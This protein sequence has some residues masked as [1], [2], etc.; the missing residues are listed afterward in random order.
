[1]T[2][3]AIDPT[4]RFSTR[5]EFYARARPRYPQA[6]LK[7][8][9]NTLGLKPVH[10]VADVGSGTGFLSELFLQNGNRVFAIEPNE[11]M[12]RKAEAALGS[13]PSFVSIDATAESTGL[14]D[15]SVDFI[16]A[17]QAF[18]W[19]DPPRA[20]REFTRILKT[21]CLGADRLERTPH[22]LRKVL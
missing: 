4:R 19:F 7:F 8:C 3:S 11:E 22:R 10:R 1:M 16:V 18:H 13:N 17:G 14:G 20:R 21:Q 15:A 9:C 6:L 2:Q 5:A 12:R